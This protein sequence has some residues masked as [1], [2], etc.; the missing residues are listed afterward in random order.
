MATGSMVAECSEPGPRLE[1][2]QLT[3]TYS[4]QADSMAYQQTE[5]YLEIKTEDAGG[6]MYYIISTE[7]WAVGD[8]DEL[9]ETLKDFRTKVER[10]S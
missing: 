6:G 7:R 5:Q 9:I 1:A 10:I 8:L 4:Q 3:A 2:I